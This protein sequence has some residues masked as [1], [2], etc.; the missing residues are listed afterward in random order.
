MSGRSKRDRRRERGA[1]WLDDN[2]PTEDNTN[3]DLAENTAGIYGLDGL[4]LGT[5]D[6]K[7]VV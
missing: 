3:R 1:S 4:D 5:S 6:R 7:S 2:P